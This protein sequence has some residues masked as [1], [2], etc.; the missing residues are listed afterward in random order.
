MGITRYDD[1]MLGTGMAPHPAMQL[2]CAALWGGATGLAAAL[3]WLRRTVRGRRKIARLRREYGSDGAV[4]YQL[5]HDHH[6]RRLSDSTVRV[7]IRQI[8]LFDGT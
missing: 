2:I 8:R 1:S 7:Y 5:L 4:I 6:D 3:R